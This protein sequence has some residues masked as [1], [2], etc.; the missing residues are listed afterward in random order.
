MLS[1]MVAVA[2]RSV[3]A[4]VEGCEDAVRRFLTWE[5]E[6][7]RKLLAIAG[8]CAR[9]LDED[10]VRAIGEGGLEWLQRYGFLMRDGKRWRYHSVVR[11]A[12]VRY[13]WQRS[14]SEWSAVHGKLAAFYEG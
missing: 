11:E 8:A 9:V 14:R 2:P 3:D 5:T 7:P 1:W 10:V 4:V 6:E 13:Q 12:M